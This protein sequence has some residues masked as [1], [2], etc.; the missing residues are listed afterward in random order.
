MAGRSMVDAIKAVSEHITH[1]RRIGQK[2]CLLALD[3]A[4]AF[5][6][7]W[8]PGI[9]ARLW[10]INCP[11][12]I[13]SLVRDFLNEC[14]AHV[15]LGNSVSSKRV[16]KGCPQGSVSG[17]NRWKIWNAAYINSTNASHTR[18]FIPTIP[19]RLSLSL[20]PNFTLMQFLTNHGKFRLYLHK[21]KN[22]SSPTCNCPERVLQTAS[23]LM[24]ECSL[25][26][27]NRLAVLHNLPLHLILKHHIHTVSV[28]SFL[29]SILN[30]LLD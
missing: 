1:C 8:H 2:C 17:L 14:T 6:S 10:N 19:L 24:A 21:M 9:L 30:S 25:F 12:N 4:G 11:P 26:S 27:H 29:S 15:T 7:A 20:W 5:D 18:Q 22:T 16:N 23:H 3:I 13:Y 28:S